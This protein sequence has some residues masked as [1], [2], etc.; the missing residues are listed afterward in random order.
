MFSFRSL[1]F[2]DEPVEGRVIDIFEGRAESRKPAL[3]F[4]HGGGWRGGSRTVFHRIIS[5]FSQLGFDCASTDYRLGAVSVFDQVADLRQG[6]DFFMRDLEDRKNRKPVV[7]IGSSAGAHLALLTGLCHP[8]EEAEFTAPPPQIAAMVVQSAPFTFEP[9]P[10]I[11]PGIWASMQ[12]AVGAPYAE[13]PDLYRKASPIQ[14]VKAGMP[15]IF[16]L[17]AENEHMFPLTHAV[18]FAEKAKAYGEAML[19]KTYSNTEHGFFY[20]LDRRQQKEAFGDIVHFLET[21]PLHSP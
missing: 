13:R 12:K 8:E 18:A 5:A 1:Y 7:L 14:Y 9:W 21:L 17:H 15:R 20:A 4:V 2:D 16:S 19:Q 6:L 10:D 11:F 3:F